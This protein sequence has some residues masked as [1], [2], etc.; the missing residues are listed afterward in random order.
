MVVHSA[1]ISKKE[2]G[3]RGDSQEDRKTVTREKVSSM[4]LIFGHL[5]PLGHI[6]QDGVHSFQ[7]V[8]PLR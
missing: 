5:D 1:I 7:G 4:V 8:F 2:R 3:E 6:V